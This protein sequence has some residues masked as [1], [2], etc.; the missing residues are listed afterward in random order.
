VNEKGY[1]KAIDIWSIGCVAGVLL[2]GNEPF[3]GAR[4]I[5]DRRSSYEATRA[6][7]A[8]RDLTWLYSSPRWEIV[9]IK[10]KS[11]VR[12]L[13]NLDE[14]DRFTA[15]QALSH[16]WYSYDRFVC[17]ALYEIA[18]MSCKIRNPLPNLVEKITIPRK[19]QK[20]AKQVR[21][22]NLWPLIASCYIHSKII[23]C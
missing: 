11:F 19:T 12:G 13:L 23:G 10:C 2:T 9:S 18:I 4:S 5:T 21:L 6:A 14:K 1:T 15:S 7:A 3:S 20:L 22:H 17:D 16:V 8:R